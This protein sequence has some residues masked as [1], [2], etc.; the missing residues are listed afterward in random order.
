MK[1]RKRSPRSPFVTD[2]ECPRGQIHALSGGKWAI[3]PVT[4][5]EVEVGKLD[6]L[7]LFDHLG[8]RQIDAV[9]R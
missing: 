1:R 8:I 5:A 4:L 9:K 2:V 6:T 7:T 3:H